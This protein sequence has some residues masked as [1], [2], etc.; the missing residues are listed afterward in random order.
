MKSLLFLLLHLLVV[1]SSAK[2]AVPSLLELKS[3]LAALDRNQAV[4]KGELQIQ[5][6]QSVQALGSLLD[7]GRQKLA[8]TRLV[9]DQTPAA[10]PAPAPAAAAATGSADSPAAVDL[11]Q[12]PQL[13]PLALPNYN[14]LSNGPQMQIDELADIQREQLALRQKK[15]VVAQQ[16]QAIQESQD[17]AS[18]L[19]Q[20][21]AVNKQIAD[22]NQQ[23]LVAA[24]QHLTDRI[25]AY[26]DRLAKE[27]MGTAATSAGASGAAGTSGASLLEASE[28]DSVSQSQSQTQ[29][30][31]TEFQQFQVQIQQQLKAQADNMQ[32]LQEILLKRR[33]R[34]HR[35]ANALQDDDDSQDDNDN[36]SQNGDH[37]TTVNAQPASS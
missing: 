35:R 17:N 9:L 14:G 29:T 25:K 34:R 24:Q 3:K 4:V 18:K 13:Q 7:E 31:T 19:Q 20:L 5:Q 23:A 10:A 26:G 22:R 37:D 1:W 27:A 15:L 33:H 21:I 32:R 12:P 8:A 36:K 16:E 2:S 6:L 11:I 30:Q 28:A